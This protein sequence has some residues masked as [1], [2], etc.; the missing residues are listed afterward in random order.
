VKSGGSVATTSHSVWIL[1][2][3]GVD[4]RAFQVSSHRVVV[5]TMMRVMTLMTVMMVMM[6]MMMVV[7]VMV[8]HRM[9]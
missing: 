3:I 8:L 1:G 7:M 9:T 2:R 5:M 4:H 6:V